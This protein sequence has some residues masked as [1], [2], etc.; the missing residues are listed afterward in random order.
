MPD[1]QNE[2][3]VDLIFPVAGLDVTTEYET[4][5]PGTT[6]VGV[7]VRSFDP[8]TGRLRGGRRPGLIK[9]I[10]ETVT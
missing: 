4:Q 10:D 7:N 6:Q 1:Q 9:F 3:Y 2:K 8:L 5:R